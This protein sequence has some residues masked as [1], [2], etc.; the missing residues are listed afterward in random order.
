MISE[1]FIKR[2]RLAIVIAIVTTLAG[3]IALTSI[4][5]AQFPEIVPPQ[6]QVTTSYPGAGADVVESTVGQPIEA[7]VVGV[8]NMLYMKSTSGNDG[9][10][11]LTI[12]FA[13]GTNPDIN[14]VNTQNRVNL[15]QPQLPDEVKRNGVSVKKKSSALLQVINLYSPENRFDALFLNNYVT[16]NILDNV[17]RVPGVGDAFLFGPLDYSMRIWVESERLTSLKITPNDIINVIRA[18]NIQ[19]AVGRIGARPIGN[20][21]EFQLNIRTQGRLTT[22]EEFNAIVVRANPDGSFVRIGDVARV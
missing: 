18:Q 17:K 3:A 1:V 14:T 9:S 15:A 4:P 12:S 16:I 20:D 11:T 2:P 8:D 7:Q 6:V 21:Q 22:V 5:V 19:A 13:V 10:Y